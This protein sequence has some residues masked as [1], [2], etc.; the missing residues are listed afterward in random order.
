MIIVE[1]PTPGFSIKKENDIDY[2]FDAIRKKWV[3]LTPEEWVRQNMVAFFTVKCQYPA[4][5]I[6]IEKQITV[7]KLMKRFDMVI[8]DNMQQPWMIVECKQ[9]DTT[10]NDEVL[11]Q[12]TN[13]QLAVKAPYMCIT[14]GPES[15]LYKVSNNFEETLSEWPDWSK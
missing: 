9:P 2:I 11:K 1:Y 15:L 6:A 10:L 12:I 14:N 8:F 4:T 3:V 5:H 13:Y 7:V